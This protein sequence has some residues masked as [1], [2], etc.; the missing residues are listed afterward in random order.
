MQNFSPQIPETFFP[1]CFLFF[2]VQD[3]EPSQ[4]DQPVCVQHGP[5]RHD[6]VSHRGAPHPNHHLLRQMVPGQAALRHPARLPGQ[7]WSLLSNYKYEVENSI[8]LKRDLYQI[9]NYLKT[10]PRN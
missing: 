7:S 6:D 2:G 4:R 3:T 1:L 9:K 10:L 5:V 8:E